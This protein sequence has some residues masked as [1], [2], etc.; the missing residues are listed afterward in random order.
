MTRMK[1]LIATLFLISSC[2][3]CNSCFSNRFIES[4]LKPYT[5]FNLPNE[6]AVVET[7]PLDAA[8]QHGWCRIQAR[9]FTSTLKSRS[10]PRKVLADNPAALSDISTSGVEL[11][12]MM[13]EML[14]R[15]D[16]PLGRAHGSEKAMGMGRTSF[17]AAS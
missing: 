9:T 2:S 15:H 7:A 12:Q 1:P 13:V 14:I 11:P 8:A 16:G 17:W 4:N 10:F 3:F 5:S 6:P